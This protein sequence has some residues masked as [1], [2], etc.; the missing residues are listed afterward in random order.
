[1]PV[2]RDGADDVTQR[3]TAGVQLCIPS[4]RLL[5]KAAVFHDSK[6]DYFHQKTN[7]VAASSAA[8]EFSTMYCLCGLLQ[9]FGISRR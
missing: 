3:R 4:H 9:L 7:Q 5:L 6:L 8:S 1:M 2:Y